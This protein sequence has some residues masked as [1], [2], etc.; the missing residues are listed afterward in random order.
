MSQALG[1][2][3]RRRSGERAQLPLEL[4]RRA[5]GGREFDTVVNLVLHSV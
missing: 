2:G 5:R 1:R 3:L 4:P